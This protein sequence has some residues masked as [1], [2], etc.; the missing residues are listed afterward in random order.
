V[1]LEQ[2]LTNLLLNAA[3]ALMARPPGAPRRIRIAADRGND[4]MVRVTVA[5][6]GGGIP[7]EILPR[8][9]EPFVTTKGP[10]RGTGLG[11]SICHGLITAM[12]GS[13]EAHN[14]AAG[15]VFVLTLAAAHAPER[16]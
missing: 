6:T 13:I 4:G 15:A 11:L 10:D 14:D 7:A 3:D 12:G 16:H 8:I 5:D 9:F 2:V 1:A